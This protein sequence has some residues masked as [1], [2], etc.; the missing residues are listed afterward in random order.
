MARSW[1]RRPGEVQTTE[2]FVF[3]H[4]GQL[5][6]KVINITHPG[7][8][9]GASSH[10]LTRPTSSLGSSF[11]Y[12]WRDEQRRCADRP[13]CPGDSIT[14]RGD[15]RTMLIVSPYAPLPFATLR[16]SHPQVIQCETPRVESWPHQRRLDA[17]RTT[18]QHTAWQRTGTKHIPYRCHGHASRAPV[19]TAQALLRL[20]P[21]LTD[22]LSLLL[23]YI[24]TAGPLC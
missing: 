22:S 11:D 14:R 6:T 19:A 3:Y 24:S 4:F 9:G 15:V 5:S 2:K 13:V 16:G 10:S 7:E 17:P 23:L 8:G 21:A 18:A 12:A 20:R 1:Q